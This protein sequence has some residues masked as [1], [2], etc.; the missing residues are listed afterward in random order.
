MLVSDNQVVQAKILACIFT[1]DFT[2]FEFIL[3]SPFLFR[4]RLIPFHRSGTFT[5]ILVRRETRVAQLT[6]LST[7]F[8]AGVSDS[9][10]SI[11]TNARIVR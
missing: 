10:Q 7:I 5:I 3:F 9:G 6:S 1:N 4:I 2:T 11:V 8:G